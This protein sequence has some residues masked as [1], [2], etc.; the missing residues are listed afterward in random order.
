MF[1]ADLEIVDD[2][3]TKFTYSPIWLLHLATHLEGHLR[4]GRIEISKLTALLK[5]TADPTAFYKL[6]AEFSGFVQ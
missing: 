4:S 3:R 2:Y 5:L 6:T 1:L